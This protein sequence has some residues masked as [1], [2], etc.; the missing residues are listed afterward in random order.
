MV[1]PFG[2]LSK[3]LG[4]TEPFISEPRRNER[5]SKKVSPDWLV[6]SQIAKAR[7]DPSNV[8][9]KQTEIKQDDKG[10]S[11]EDGRELWGKK[12]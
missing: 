10:F 11:D 4:R 5:Y 2:S 12:W 9:R 8:S 6:A 3:K 1:L 7:P